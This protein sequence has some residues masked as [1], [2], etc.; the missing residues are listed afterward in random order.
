MAWVDPMCGLMLAF[1][2]AAA[3]WQRRQTGHVARIDFSMIE[4]LL[5]TMADPLLTAQLSGPPIPLGNDAPDCAPHGVWR[6][7]GPD[8][9]IAVAVPDQ[10]AWHA[11]CA[12]VPALADWF[13]DR[14]GSQG[15]EALTQA[16]VPAA[17]AATSLNLV[18]D[19]HLRVREFWEASEFGLMPGLPWHA[20]FGKASG[21]A[22]A[23]GADTDAVLTDV[24][25]MAPIEISN[26]R[27]S[28][29]IR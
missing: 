17:A 22:P 20:S 28:G 13:R 24:L 15:A 18:A 4:A 14:N 16:G 2:A 7:A 5:W 19:D 21:P 27:Q 8:D 6:C 12:T 29:A 3:I 26:L 25:G 10:A 1:S 23:L 9:W 11:L